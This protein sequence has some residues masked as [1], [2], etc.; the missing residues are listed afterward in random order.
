MGENANGK[1]LEFLKH[2]K[3]KRVSQRA[4]KV[5]EKVEQYVMAYRADHDLIKKLLPKEFS[6]LRPVL[7]INAE[8]R[9]QDEE[10]RHYIEFNTPVEGFGKRGWLNIHCFETA[11]TDISVKKYD[12][13]TEF[14][15]PEL[16]ISF[17]RTGRQGGCPA[18]ADNDGCFYIYDEYL[19]IP[20]ETISENKEYCECGFEWHIDKEE[21]ADN[22][23][24]R[25]AS[26]PCEEVLGAY[27]VSF[28]RDRSA[29]V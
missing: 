22:R 24:I 9:T 23:F 19:F 2:L 16:S 29:K 27:I 21:Y 13:V 8:I 14:F 3:E 20:E 15:C 11:D 10:V 25:A 5:P 7:R 4:S 28:I 1:A 26:I 6:S 17:T 12:G 18:E